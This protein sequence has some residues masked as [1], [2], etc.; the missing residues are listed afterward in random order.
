MLDNWRRR[1]DGVGKNQVTDLKRLEQESA[2]LEKILAQRE[3]E[4]DAMKEIGLARKPWI[5]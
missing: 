3:L 1:F 5:S 4:I 2:R